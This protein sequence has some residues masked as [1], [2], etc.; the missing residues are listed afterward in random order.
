[1][2]EIDLRMKANWHV[3]YNLRTGEYWIRCKNEAFVKDAL[4]ELCRTLKRVKMVGC[5][6]G[7]K[8]HV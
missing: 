8:H 1:M 7:G 2:I 3:V 6:H 4:A 5:C